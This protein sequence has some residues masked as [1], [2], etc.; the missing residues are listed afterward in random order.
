[1]TSGTV[2]ETSCVYTS[3]RG[4]MCKGQCKLPQP[5]FC[6]AVLCVDQ[7]NVRFYNVA[8]MK[9]CAN[10]PRTLCL[11]ELVVEWKWLNWKQGLCQSFVWEC[12]TEGVK[13]KTEGGEWRSA[14][15]LCVRAALLLK[16]W[17]PHPPVNLSTYTHT[18]PYPSQI[19]ATCF[20][21]LNLERALSH[22]GVRA[23]TLYIFGTLCFIRHK[24]LW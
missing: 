10:F 12:K 19:L 14:G 18:H 23:L 11:V 1:M 8:L 13:E 6:S 3:Y 5:L 22:N 21:L 7:L 17:P 24:I 20:R 2:P 4:L 16:P 9:M 15:V